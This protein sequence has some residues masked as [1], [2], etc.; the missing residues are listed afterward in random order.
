MKDIIHD[1]YITKNV[2]HYKINYKKHPK[3]K[4]SKLSTYQLMYS[5]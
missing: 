3:R 1:L 4:R 2:F 5:G